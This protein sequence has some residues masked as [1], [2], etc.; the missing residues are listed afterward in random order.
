[1]PKTVNSGAMRLGFR[2]LGFAVVTNDLRTGAVW[3]IHLRGGEVPSA[4]DVRRLVEEVTKSHRRRPT[5]LEIYSKITTSNKYLKVIP[6]PNSLGERI[7]AIVAEWNS[8]IDFVARRE[9]DKEYLRFS[10]SLVDSEGN[11][12]TEKR[13]GVARVIP[14]GDNFIWLRDFTRGS[15]SKLEGNPVTIEYQIWGPRD[16]Y[17]EGAEAAGDVR[18]IPKLIMACWCRYHHFWSYDSTEH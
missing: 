11:R 2:C 16:L 7:D 4:E 15:L 17:L 9:A 10:V 18:S 5:H 8:Q 14:N 6:A 13:E 1:M 3:Q 12:V